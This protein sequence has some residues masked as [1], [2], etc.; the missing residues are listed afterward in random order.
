[1]DLGM[2]E[3]EREGNNF[4][5]KW[6]AA[7]YDTIL[8]IQDTSGS[9][10]PWGVVEEADVLD[11]PDDPSRLYVAKSWGIFRLARWSC[12]CTLERFSGGEWIDEPLDPGLLLLTRPSAA[13]CES[14]ALNYVEEIPHLQR[15]SASRFTF[16]Q[17]TVLRLLRWGTA[18]MTLTEEVPVLLWLLAYRVGTGA[19]AYDLAGRLLQGKRRDIIAACCGAS[20]PFSP[21]WFR[22]IQPYAFDETAF[23]GLA[24]LL[25]QRGAWPILSHYSR[26][27]PESIP[28]NRGLVQYLRYLPVRN[29]IERG[30]QTCSLEKIFVTIN[31]I[32][33]LAALCPEG[34]A[35][36]KTLKRI[37]TE[38]GLVQLLDFV[39]RQYHGAQEYYLELLTKYGPLLPVPPLAGTD[40]IVPVKTLLELR[41]EGESMHH[42]VYTFAED[43]YKGKT[44]I[45]RVLAPQRA[46][47]QLEKRLL[48]WNVAN[49]WSYSN[50]EPSP[51]TWKAVKRWCCNATVASL[52]GAR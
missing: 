29:S 41:Q 39:A 42:R 48:G 2:L 6:G 31:E 15:I 21:R 16:M 17:W 35:I 51:E 10:K 30:A 18:A 24:F 37:K 36:L 4:W 23:A 34:N 12:H 50:D 3:I 33:R 11:V 7:E 19:I 40:T 13:P 38:Q 47:L 43:I 32:K 46:T 25:R 49:M 27:V 1:M 22:K 52:T 20:A 44:A 8:T 28:I 5:K 9:S 45:Y 14:H 26:I